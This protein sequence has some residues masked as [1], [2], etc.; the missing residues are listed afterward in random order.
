MD[1]ERVINWA[2]ELQG[3]SKAEL[4]R[5]TGLSTGTISKLG[6]QQQPLDDENLNRLLDI[7]QIDTSSA[8]VKFKEG[9]FIK[10]LIRDNFLGFP[11]YQPLFEVLD[12]YH[13]EQINAYMVM[14]ED[15]PQLDELF[16]KYIMPEMPA[17]Y[18]IV[19]I[20][21]NR[22]LIFVGRRRAYLT[23]RGRIE[24]VL[25][26]QHG[27]DIIMVSDRNVSFD[28][29]DETFITEFMERHMI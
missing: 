16:Q 10:I 14:A 18:L 12:M 15:I 29:A 21:N 9:S 1:K 4:S 11:S 25:R 8:S 3:I 23:Y 24:E 7:L 17:S 5:R 19:A 26:K 20:G 28:R 6:K 27:A 2:L 22:L 13:G